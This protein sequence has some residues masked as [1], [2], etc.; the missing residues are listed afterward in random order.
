MEHPRALCGSVL[1]CKAAKE[2]LSTMISEPKENGLFWK[3]VL[4]ATGRSDA[5]IYEHLRFY[6][7]VRRSV[8][9]AVAVAPS[10]LLLFRRPHSRVRLSGAVGQRGVAQVVFEN[11]GPL[12]VFCVVTLGEHKGL[13]L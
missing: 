6:L 5:L 4:F 3:R 11:R 12:V 8:N 7:P 10:L 13:L 2:S 1:T 9:E